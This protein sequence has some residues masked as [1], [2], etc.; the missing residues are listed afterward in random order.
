LQELR[1]NPLLGTYT[2]M[3]AARNK[4]PQL[5]E[6]ICPFCPP[7]NNLSNNYTVCSYDNDYP[8][9]YLQASKASHIAGPYHSMPPYGKCAVILYDSDH[10]KTLAQFT[11][12]EYIQLIYHWQRRHTALSENHLLKYIFIFENKSEEVG[13]TLH[14]PHGQLYAYPFIPLKIETE[15]RNA[16]P[17]YE[18]KYENLFDAIIRREQNDKKSIILEYENFIAL[19]PYFT[20]YLFGVFIIAKKSDMPTFHNFTEYTTNDLAHILQKIL[21][22]FDK[23]YDRSFP[24]MKCIHQAPI[25]TYEYT[26]CEN[27]FRF[28]IEFYPPLRATNKIKYYASSEMGAWAAANPT[29]IDKN[30]SLLKNLIITI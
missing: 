14:H 10:H 29:D 30:A 23:I 11:P 4:R 18:N 7:N 3:A 16:K 22:A 28:H 20:D 12:A 19:I 13:V 17:Y 15:L 24:Y 8:V 1:W 2:M 5:P 27:Y 9:M 6:D 26:D 21:A 25:H